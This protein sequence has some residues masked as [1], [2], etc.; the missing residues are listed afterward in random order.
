MA[1]DWIASESVQ[2]Q[3]LNKRLKLDNQLL[4]A[5]M[6]TTGAPASLPADVAQ[7]HGELLPGRYILQAARRTHQFLECRHM[8]VAVGRICTREPQSRVRAWR[9]N[10]E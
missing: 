2:R 8:L 7:M 4:N 1:A 10:A 6:D 5:N 3:Q 9:H